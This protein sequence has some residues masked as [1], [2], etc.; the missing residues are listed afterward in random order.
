MLNGILL[1]FFFILGVLSGVIYNKY[2]VKDY[3][4]YKRKIGYF[5][6]IVVFVIAFLSIYSVI[7]IRSYVNSIIK[8]YSIRLEQ[9]IKENNPENELVK[10]GIDLTQFKDSLA[11]VD[12]EISEIKTLLPDYKELGV[13]KIIYDL[14]VN[15]A[16]KRLQKKLEVVNYYAYIVDTFTEKNNIITVSSLINGLRTNVIKLINMVSLIIV[17]IFLMV[18]FVYIIYTLTIITRER[19]FKKYDKGKN[20]T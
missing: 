17:L 7:S 19:K 9:Y 15:Y 20:G 5:F 18:F 12:N 8:E 14:I 3:P 11:Q 1:M 16:I 4:D 10:N 6:T 2:F 13:D